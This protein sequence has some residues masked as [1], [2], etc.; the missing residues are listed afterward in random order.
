MREDNNIPAERAGGV[1]C[2]DLT[3]LQNNWKQLAKMSE[4]AECGAAVKAQCYGIGLDE[5]VKA[6]SAVGCKTYFVALPD[7]GRQV[8]EAAP[9]AIIYV[10]CGLLSGQAKFYEKYDLRPALATPT[11]VSEWQEFCKIQNKKLPAALHIESGINRLGLTETQT[12]LLAKQ[13]DAFAYFKLTL[14]MS[15]LACGDTP[16]DLKNE[17]QRQKFDQMRALLP[18]VPASLSNSP[19]AFLGRDFAYDMVRPGIAL[20]GGNPFSDRANPMTSVAHLYAPLLQVRD[21]CAGET[22]GYSATWTA[23]RDTKIG[24]IGAGYRDGISRALSSPA[25]NGPACVFVGGHYAPI[26][27]RVSMDLITVDLTDIPEEFQHEGQKVELMGRNITVDD[28]ARWSGTIAYDVLTSL[29]S[30]YAR[31]YSGLESC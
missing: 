13:T 15:H 12:R 4:P 20:Y 23:K 30:R 5:S 1:L 17:E 29:G 8:R 27:G 10:L 3:A 6:L 7:E 26:V 9:D 21:I 24:I 16:G 14:V 19:G 31:V 22:V 25:S 11:Q 2:I 18:D 28:I